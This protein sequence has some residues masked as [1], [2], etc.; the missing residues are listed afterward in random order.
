[1]NA[2]KS[3]RAYAAIVGLGLGFYATVRAQTG[4][5]GTPVRE[6][7]KTIFRY[8]GALTSWNDL[9]MIL[10]QR[11]PQVEMVNAVWTVIGECERNRDRQTDRMVVIVRRERIEFYI[12][13]RFEQKYEL[14]LVIGIPFDAAGRIGRVIWWTEGG[15]PPIEL[16]E[17]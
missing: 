12:A 11:F 14:T 5:L 16:F 3:I 7:A 15:A 2:A 9:T 6:I 17:E 4:D 10:R 1:M 13:R 8:D